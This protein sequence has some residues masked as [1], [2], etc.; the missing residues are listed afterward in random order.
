[1]KECDNSKIHISSNFILSISLLIMLDTLLLRPSITTLQHSAT[2]HHI[3]ERCMVRIS[4]FIVSLTTLL[5]IQIIQ[6]DSG[7]KVTVSVVARKNVHMNV[8][9]N[10]EWL[11]R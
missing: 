7:G 3:I 4:L 11:P 5:M 6:S 8:C 2:L 1:M 9:S 10:S